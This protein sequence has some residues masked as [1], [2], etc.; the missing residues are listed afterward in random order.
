MSRVCELTGK[1]GRWVTMFPTPTQDQ[2]DLSAQPAERDPAVRSAREERQAACFDAR[3]AFGRACRRPRQCW[4]RP[5]PRSF[6]RARPSSSVNSPRR[7]PRGVSCCRLGRQRPATHVPAGRSS[8]TN[9]VRIHGLKLSSLTIHSR[10]PHPAGPRLR[11]LPHCRARPG[12]APA[13]VP[14]DRPRADL[15]VTGEAAPGR[16][17]H[18]TTSVRR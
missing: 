1:G 10:V 9:S 6:R 8:A 4:S 7:R 13:R 16:P 12:A 18:S 17:P 2:A 11:F 15:Q 5:A 3:P 14:P